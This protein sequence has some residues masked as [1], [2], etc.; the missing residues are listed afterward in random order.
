MDQRIIV[1]TG[2][3]VAFFNRR[4]E[5]HHW[6][7]LQLSTLRGT[8]VTTES[9]ISEC[10]Y[11]LGYSNIAISAIN[12]MVAN[13]KLI[14]SDV[15]TQNISEVL[16]LVDKYQDLPASLADATLMVVYNSMKQA[17]ILTLDSD[18]KIYRARD[19]KPPVLIAPF[20]Q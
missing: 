16:K 15:P 14:V 8:L 7:L 3:L 5:Y 9:V 19:G 12:E 4:D 6:V 20:E 13:R 1:D 2:P 11:L 10:L 17:K 18:F